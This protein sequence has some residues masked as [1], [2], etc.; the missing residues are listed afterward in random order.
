MSRLISGSET[1]K[2]LASIITIGN[3]IYYTPFLHKKGEILTDLAR[4]PRGISKPCSFQ[5]RFSFLQSKVGKVPYSPHIKSVNNVSL[6]SVKS[7]F[8]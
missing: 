8:S 5:D 1:K 6:I 2:K 4:F 3:R 7:S